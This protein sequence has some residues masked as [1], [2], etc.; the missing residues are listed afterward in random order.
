MKPRRRTRAKVVSRKH[1]NPDWSAL[2]GKTKE[3]A[4]GVKKSAT[5]LKSG[6]A[7]DLYKFMHDAT[8]STPSPYPLAAQQLK[9]IFDSLK[10]AAESGELEAGWKKEYADWFGDEA[11]INFYAAIDHRNFSKAIQTAAGKKYIDKLVSDGFIRPKIA[12]PS[13]R[14][15]NP[16]RPA[17]MGLSPAEI[18]RHVAGEA[19]TAKGHHALALTHYR[20]S[21][22][23]NVRGDYAK[24][25]YHGQM[26]HAHE[27]IARSLEGVTRAIAKRRR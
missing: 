4:K 18:R 25:D 3:K 2:W 15:R 19:S 8:Y 27:S 1:G 14:R 12:N 23:F 24:A 16:E 6:S 22:K 17:P 11:S 7:A 26:A 13:R 10:R 9:P 20:E 21:A 5:A